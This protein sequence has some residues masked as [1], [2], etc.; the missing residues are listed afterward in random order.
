MRDAREYPPAL[1]GRHSFDVL[2]IGGGATGMGIAWDACLRGMDVVV[3]EA[4]E[5]AQGTS[6]RYHGLLHSGG[7]YAVSDPV[8]AADCAR[9]NAILRQIAPEA[10]EDTGGLF[11]A[12]K[13]DPEDYPDRWLKGCRE[14]GVWV[15]EMSVSSARK[16]EPLLTEEISRAFE[17]RDGSLDSFDLLHALR[18]NLLHRGA[19]VLLEHRVNGL[20]REDGIV[21]GAE[22]FGPD[23]HK[24]FAI[25]ARRTIN[26]AGPWAAEVA[27]MAGV[28]IPMALGK[29]TMLAMASRL[30]HT[31]INRCRLPGD[32]DIVVPVGTVMVLGT[33]DVPVDDPATRS[34]EPWEVD[35]LMDE[36]AALI[37]CL[38]DHRPLRA[39]AGIRPLY[40][41]PVKED[42]TRELPRSHVVLDHARDG[43]EGFISVFGGKLTTF[44]LMA[45]ETID[46]IAPSLGNIQPCHTHDVPLFEEGAS[47]YSLPSR[48]QRLERRGERASAPNLVCECEMVTHEDVLHALDR[49]GCQSLDTLRRELRIGM[50]PCQ[51]SFCGYR[52]AGIVQQM[53]ADAP[54]DGGLLSFIQER[55]RGNRPVAWGHT[56]RQMAFSRRVYM[57]LLNVDGL[58][59]VER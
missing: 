51:A 38:S 48:L 58:D 40:H 29:G 54:P 55:W 25:R 24:P 13:G 46:R 10:I 16:R 50:G 39:W 43:A 34:I 45:Q 7:R 30:V 9:E 47:Y 22:V 1:K 20:I 18:A 5:L 4:Q 32:G 35:M 28:T 52:T 14:T 49:C 3:V 31:V 19:S 53:D 42:E 36:A 6:G 26:A 56:L 23:K 27:R 44:R 15:Q 37:P 8:S 33:S 21:V 57:E 11:V 2:V 17:V 41:P 12:L 59:G